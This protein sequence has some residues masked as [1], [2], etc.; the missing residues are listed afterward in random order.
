MLVARL[1][2][3]DAIARLNL[4]KLIKVGIHFPPSSLYMV[5]Y[6]LR[7]D[8]GG[9]FFFFGFSPVHSIYKLARNHEFA[10]D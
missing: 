1:D 3:Q 2:H 6:I 10:A 4:L 8:L 5:D 7:F 9:F